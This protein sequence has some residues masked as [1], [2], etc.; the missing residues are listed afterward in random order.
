MNCH[1]CT[2]GGS[3]IDGSGGGGGSSYVSQDVFSALDPHPV[4]LTASIP[5]PILVGHFFKFIIC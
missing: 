2:G 3:G 1:V 5:G 4:Q